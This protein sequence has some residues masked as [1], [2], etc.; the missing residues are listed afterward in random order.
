MG[1]LKHDLQNRR[2]QIIS[3]NGKMIEEGV[4]KSV[5]IL[6]QSQFDAQKEAKHLK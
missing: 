3:E 1:V 6:H 5:K 2:I 4:F